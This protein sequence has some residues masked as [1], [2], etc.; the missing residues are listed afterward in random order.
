MEETIA[1]EVAPTTARGA[2]AWRVLGF[3]QLPPDRSRPPVNTR[4]HAS[5][6][7]GA[8]LALSVIAFFFV[9]TSYYVIRPVRLAGRGL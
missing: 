1:A 8:T 4:R 7:E 6:G 3:R 5:L 2:A 9:M